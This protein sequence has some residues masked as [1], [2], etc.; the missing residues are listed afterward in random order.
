M[1]PIAPLFPTHPTIEFNDRRYPLS[2][3]RTHA[4][5]LARAGRFRV[6]AMHQ[7]DIESDSYQG[8]VLPKTLDYRAQLPP[9]RD[10]GPRPICG[11]ISLATVL[12]WKHW[13]QHHAV[14][15]PLAPEYAYALRHDKT[16]AGMSFGDLLDVAHNRGVPTQLLYDVARKDPLNEPAQAAVDADAASRKL[17]GAALIETIE[18]GK[19]ALLMNGPCPIFLPCYN[20]S[21]QFWRPTPQ[22]VV[23]M[24]KAP[25]SERLM[26]HATVLV[27]WEPEGFLLRNSWSEAFGR[28]GYTTFP[29]SDWDQRWEMWTCVGETAGATSTSKYYQ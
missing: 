25:P 12:E 2:V 13:H 19:A 1:L 24:S 26:G 10:Q 22:D 21:N 8:L 7:A 5:V 9:V 14:S 29:F 18:M 23:R 28:R 15:T 16:R 4:D 17:A 20:G 3:V 27:G 6:D 11:A